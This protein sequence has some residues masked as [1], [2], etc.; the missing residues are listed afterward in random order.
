MFQTNFR[1]RLAL[2][3]LLAVLCGVQLVHAWE[4]ITEESVKV[5]AEIYVDLCA[6]GFRV[7][8]WR[9]PVTDGTTPEEKELDAFS[10]NL[11]ASGHRCPMIFN[12]QLG[13]GRS[14]FGK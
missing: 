7:H 1:L 12:C 11:S 4:R 10:A 6:Q 13:L 8:Y 3:A 9:V 5:P 14:T 2:S